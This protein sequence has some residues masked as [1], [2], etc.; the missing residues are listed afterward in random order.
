MRLFGKPAGRCWESSFKPDSITEIGGNQS[1]FLISCDCFSPSWSLPA[2]GSYWV[3]RPTRFRWEYRISTSGCLRRKSAECDA[4]SMGSASAGSTQLHPSVI[5]FGR[6]LALLLT[7]E[8]A[9][10]V[11]RIKWL[12]HEHL[13]Y[14]FLFDIFLECGVCETHRT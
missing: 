13:G 5:L 3:A 2:A 6:S 1:V 8:E 14:F 7:L 10:R 12:P 4:K 11:E 9:L